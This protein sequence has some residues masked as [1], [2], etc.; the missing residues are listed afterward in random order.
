MEQ[1]WVTNTGIPTEYSTYFGEKA[2]IAFPF[3]SVLR[4]PDHQHLEIGVAISDHQ[5]DDEVPPGPDSVVDDD[6]RAR[7]EAVDEASAFEGH[8]TLPEDSEFQ[9]RDAHHGP[10]AVVQ[11]GAPVEGLADVTEINPELAS[12]DVIPHALPHMSGELLPLGVARKRE[13]G[14]RKESIK[15]GD[16]LLTPCSIGP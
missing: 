2:A 6:G 4:E 9:V 3:A 12:P 1:N 15:F 16:A 5:L 10:A 14:V 8:G 7:G 13:R 11:D